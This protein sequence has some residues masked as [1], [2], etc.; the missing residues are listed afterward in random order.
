[1]VD[2]TRREVACAAEWD[3]GRA[4][5]DGRRSIESTR[6][7][8]EEL[9]QA[10]RHEVA[11][12]RDVGIIERLGPLEVPEPPVEV[13]G[14]EVGK[15]DIGARRVGADHLINEAIGEW[16]AQCDVAMGRT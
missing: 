14:I 12:G 16:V 11:F 13:V 2:R 9:R 1:M 6:G 10:A 5:G 4:I 15:G 3:V 7:V 8:G